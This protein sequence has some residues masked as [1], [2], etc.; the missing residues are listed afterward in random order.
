LHKGNKNL[1]KICI[2][3]RSL[4]SGG[5]E[6]QATLL[7]KALNSRFRVTL[8]IYYNHGSDNYLFRI[9]KESN[10]NIIIL[11]GT[12]ISKIKQIYCLFKKSKFKYIFSYLLL[13]NLIG[14]II[15]RLANVP[16]TIG[17]IRSSVIDRNK[18]FI[19][20]F[21]QNYI[22]T[23]T[24][25]NNYK[26]IV[27]LKKYSYNQ[28]KSILIPNCFE[29]SNSLL[30]RNKKNVNFIL[31]VGRFVDVKDYKTA[32]KAIKFLVSL[33]K[34]SIFYKIIGYGPLEPNI[35]EWINEL[36]LNDFVQLLINPNDLDSHYKEADIYLSTSIFEGMS[37][38][39]MEAMSF[40]LP[41]VATNVGDNDILIEN[42]VNGYLANVGDHLEIA[43]KLELLIQSYKNRIN[44]GMKSYQKLK[45]N[46]GMDKFR[47]NYIKLIDEL[48]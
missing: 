4:Q 29:V 22:N 3:V 47:E 20:R 11:K 34:Y 8:L 39:V 48:K 15:G 25:Y 37:N 40:S 27:N 32:L 19:N 38:T 18:L 42:D 16:Y 6:K 12:H 35:R 21:L 17:G 7:A 31:S 5:A 13:P 26:G 46:F 2:F 45:Q 43:S 44:M 36:E 33:K 9:V 24:I 30:I 10:I 28:N 23:I 1:K 14:G 41:I